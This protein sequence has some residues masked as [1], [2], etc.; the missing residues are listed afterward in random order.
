MQ[1]GGY[2]EAHGLGI[3]WQKGESFPYN[4]CYLRTALLATR[5]RIQYLQGHGYDDIDTD[6]RGNI[7]DAINGITQALAAL[8]M[9]VRRR[10]MQ[11]KQEGI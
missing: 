2:A 8:D 7:V 4:G 11:G 10:F 9:V 1:D 6:E 3:R 5:Q